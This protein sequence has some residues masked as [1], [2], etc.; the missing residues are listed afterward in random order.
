MQARN[1]R[2]LEA[3]LGISPQSVN[4]FFRADA[5]DMAPVWLRSVDEPRGRTE[6]TASQRARVERG[7]VLLDFSIECMWAHSPISQIK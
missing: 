2:E 3:A 4:S 1:P 7:N 6:L 5:T